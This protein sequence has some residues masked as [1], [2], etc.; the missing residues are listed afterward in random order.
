MDCVPASKNLIPVDWPR[1]PVDG[2]LREGP[3]NHNKLILVVMIHLS[4]LATN[5][6][7]F[8]MRVLGLNFHR[9]EPKHWCCKKCISIV[10]FFMPAIW[11]EWYN[12]VVDIMISWPC[13]CNSC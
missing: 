6:C 10:S 9:S 4:L 3:L 11:H 13:D 1:R 12:V 5:P 2:V 7:H 8:Y